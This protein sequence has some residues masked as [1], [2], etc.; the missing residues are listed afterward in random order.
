MKTCRNRGER[1]AR[2]ATRN[3][4]QSSKSGDVKLL[5]CCCKSIDLDETN[6]TSTETASNCQILVSAERS[7]HSAYGFERTWN[8]RRWAWS[9]IVREATS[10]QQRFSLL[11][12]CARKTGAA[13][14]RLPF[15]SRRGPARAT[16]RNSGCT[17]QGW[18]L[19]PELPTKRNNLH[20]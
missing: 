6:N 20:K 11:L 15:P 4:L 19:V 17:A 9:E 12:R 5:E 16:G 14:L 10:I 1:K 2:P 3:Q 7:H 13:I 8:R 18:G